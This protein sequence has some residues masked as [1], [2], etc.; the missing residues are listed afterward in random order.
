MS[1]GVEGALESTSSRQL[2]NTT[3]C[4]SGA[5]SNGKVNW[6][7]RMTDLPVILLAAYGREESIRSTW[8]GRLIRFGQTCENINNSVLRLTLVGIGLDGMPYSVALQYL[9]ADGSCEISSYIRRHVSNPCRPGSL[10]N[11]SAFPLGNVHR[12]Q[13]WGEEWLQIGGG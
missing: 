5:F 1:Q 6:N 3:W 9:W 11:N 8:S 7:S 12:G 2:D 13:W 10:G 4:S